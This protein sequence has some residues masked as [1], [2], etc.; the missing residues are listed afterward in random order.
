MLA[1]APVV[2]KVFDRSPHYEHLLSGF[3]IIVLGGIVVAELM[4]LSYANGGWLVIPLAILG[5]TGPTLIEKL[6]Q[7][8]ADSTHQLT[9]IIGFSGLLLHVM[10][11][12][13]SLNEYKSI[14]SASKW[15]PFAIVLHRVPVALSVLWI[16]RPVFGIKAVWYA[17]AGLSI[18]TLFG[19]VL[20]VQME[21]AMNSQSFACLQAFVSGTL[22]H[23]LLH[24]PHRHRGNGHSHNGHSHGDQSDNEKQAH[25]HHHHNIFEQFNHWGRFHLIGVVIGV[26]T[27]TLLSLLH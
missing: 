12:G 13:A 25:K 19:Y 17:L 26:I 1:I 21:S 16:I 11:D 22:L 5:L 8:A 27:L 7:K 10:V 6:F 24:R 9:L 15:L 20:G 4:P 3:L 2:A 14:D 18:F 23:V